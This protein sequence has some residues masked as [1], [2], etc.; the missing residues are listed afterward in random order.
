MEQK[1]NYMHINPITGKWNFV[2]NSTSY[3]HSSASYKLGITQHF[4][5]RHFRN[6]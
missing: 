5:P 2:I 6:W 3:E 1:L 4:S